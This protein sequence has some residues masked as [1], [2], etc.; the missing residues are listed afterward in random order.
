MG[1]STA[2]RNTLALLTLLLPLTVGFGVNTPRGSIALPISGSPAELSL[3]QGDPNDFGDA[4]ESY[5]SADHVIVAWQYLGAG[6]DGERSSLF[7]DNADGDDLNGTDDED[8]I[9]IPSLRQGDKA[10]I[11]YTVVSFFVAAYLNAWIDWNGDGDFDD[12]NEQIASNVRHG[13]G[14]YTLDITVPADAI[15]TGPTFA[16]FRL[17]PRSTSDPVYGSTGTA[18]SGEVEDYMIKIEC[19]QPDPP[20]IGEISQPSCQVPTGSVSLENLPSTGTWT[21]TRSPDG[22]T[23]TGTGSTYIDAGLTQGTYSY[24]VTNQGGC[25]SEPSEEIVINASLQV[26][27]TPVIQEVVQPGCTVTTGEVLLG[28]LPAGESWVVILYPNMALYPGTGTTLRITGLQA[29]TYYF[30]VRNSDGCISLPTEDVIISDEPVYPSAPVIDNIT[31]PSCNVST[32]I[33]DISGLPPSGTWTLTRYPGSIN[34]SGTG[35]STIVTGLPSGTYTFTVTDAGGCTSEPSSDVI[36]NTQP[37]TPASPDPGTVIQPTCEVPTGSVEINGLP[38][39]GGW[40]LTRFPGTVT[41]TGSGTS[42]TIEGLN[43]GTYNFTVTNSYDCTSPV[44]TAVVIDQQP[45][46]FPT[47]VIH[48][49]SPVCPGE[50]TDLTRPEITAGSTSGLIFT[51]WHNAQATDPMSAPAAAPEGIYYIKGSIP[52]GCSSI[53]PVVVQTIQIPMADAGPDQILT[54]L[55]STTL[56]AVA[57]D[58]NFTGTW[59]VEEGSGDFTDENDPKTRVS[60]LSVGENMLMWS[61]SN[62]VCPPTTDNMTITVT[63]LLI[64]SLITP[65]MNGMNDYF[66]LQGMEELGRVE[67]TVFDRRGL[68]VFENHDYDNLW[69]G[70][71]YNGNPLPDDTYFY[72]IEAE[73]GASLAGYIVIRRE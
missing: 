14:T 60:N 50:T 52:G 17:G 12:Q 6:V 59:S 4:P 28:N 35:V 46:P 22:E 57:P 29:G 15:T 9:V 64:P 41:T 32:G 71:D 43:P 26:P 38:S 73:N 55:F 37:P 65:D 27:E 40:V 5:G 56:N 16:R 45:G 39:E 11:Q 68:I 49:P 58:G 42:I 7:S 19:V 21:L 24:T 66:V 61:V 31:Q 44:S 2:K 13:T 53:E 8:G 33:V 25:T 10:S 36:I 34:Y 47:L 54:Y 18:S 72:I 62:D 70:L 23:V 48:N 69:Y 63:N 51:Y 1:N 20:R 30:A 67:L 3:L